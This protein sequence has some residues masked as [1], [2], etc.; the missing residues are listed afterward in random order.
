MK[1]TGSHQNFPSYDSKLKLA[2]VVS[3]FNED[4]CDGLLNGAIATLKKIGFQ[5]NQYQVLRV[6]GAFEIPL[7]TQNLAR[8][9][10]YDGIICLGAVI[11]GDTAHFDFVCQSVTS[12]LTRV[13]LD[14]SIPIGFGIITTDTKEQALERSGDNNFNKG[15]ETVVTVLEMIGLLKAV[16]PAKAGISQVTVGSPPSRG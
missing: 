12:G 11:R 8:Q 10:K 14:E 4:I 5:E 6:P 2:L 7:L 1:Q 16:I 15:Y 13:Q 3:R 9:K